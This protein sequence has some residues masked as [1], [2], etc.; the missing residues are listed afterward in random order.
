MELQDIENNI[1]RIKRVQDSA[2]PALAA[3]YRQRHLQRQNAAGGVADAAAAKS[4]SAIVELRS[5]MSGA[6]GLSASDAEIAAR[7][8]KKF[9]DPKSQNRKAAAR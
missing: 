9:L 1:A 5:A 7:T 3:L 4:E 6:D 8:M 2:E